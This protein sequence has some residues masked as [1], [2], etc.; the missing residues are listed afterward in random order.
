MKDWIDNTFLRLLKNDEDLMLVLT[1]QAASLDIA[2]EANRQ[3]G[4]HSHE[5]RVKSLVKTYLV[6]LDCLKYCGFIKADFLMDRQPDNAGK[7]DEENIQEIADSAYNGFIKAKKN[8]K[9]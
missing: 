4:P 8:I 5:H 7:T 9:K 6:L 3:E 2:M 1:S